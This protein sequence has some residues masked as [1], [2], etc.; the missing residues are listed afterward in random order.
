MWASTLQPLSFLSFLS[1]FSTSLI[2]SP[3]SSVHQPLSA[4]ALILTPPCLGLYGCHP[5]QSHSRFLTRVPMPRH[6]NRLPHTHTHCVP[7]S[8]H[9]AAYS[10]SS[11][12]TTWPELWKWAGSRTCWQWVLQWKCLTPGTLGPRSNSPLIAYHCIVWSLINTCLTNDHSLKPLT[13]NKSELTSPESSQK[14]KRRTTVLPVQRYD[15]STVAR[16]HSCTFASMKWLL[17]CGQ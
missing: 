8:P 11:V 17:L 4:T 7:L 13:A 16:L 14:S 10:P 2:C 12:F 1:L 6:T 3:S 15:P 9:S 5:A